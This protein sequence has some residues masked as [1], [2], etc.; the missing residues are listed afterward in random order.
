[1]L[2]IGLGETT[3]TVEKHGASKGAHNQELH[4]QVHQSASRCLCTAVCACKQQHIACLQIQLNC[5]IV[6]YLA[7]LNVSGDTS[8][9]YWSSACMMPPLLQACSSC[10]CTRRTRRNLSQVCPTAPG[11][12]SDHTSGINQF[13]LSISQHQAFSQ[14][15]WLHEAKLL[16]EASRHC[17]ELL[18][19]ND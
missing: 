1:M 7:C 19:K 16:P 8:I 5:I 9:C 6:I 4:V 3:K 13:V 10:P 18:P 17:L 14:D 15:T 2:L 12:S 11:I